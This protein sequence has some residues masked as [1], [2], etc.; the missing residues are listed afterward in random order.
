M[1]LCTQLFDYTHCRIANSPLS[2]YLSPFFQFPPTLSLSLLPPKLYLH[3]SDENGGKRRKKIDHQKKKKTGLALRQIEREKRKIL[4][5][6]LATE[7][8]FPEKCEKLNFCYFIF[9]NLI[10]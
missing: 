9:G 4:L 5:E 10:F 2:F 3:G 1:P 6:I 8:Y 7:S